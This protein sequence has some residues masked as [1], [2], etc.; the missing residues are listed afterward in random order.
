MFDG[1]ILLAF[2]ITYTIEFETD[3]PAIEVLAL[4]HTSRGTEPPL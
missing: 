4:W 3:S 1:F 2:T